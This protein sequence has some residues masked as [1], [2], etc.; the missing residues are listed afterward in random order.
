MNNLRQVTLWGQITL[1]AASTLT[2]MAGATI[3]PSLPA[4]QT[5]FESKENAGFL[6][7]LVLT[8]PALFIV[9]GAPLAGFLI[10]HF[11]RKT[12]LLI[13][14][15]LYAAAGSSGFFLDSLTLILVGRALLGLAVAGIMTSVT[16]LIAD[17]FTGDARS[18]LLG[19]QASFMALGGVLFLLFGGLL[20]DLSWRYPFLIYLFPLILL[21]LII[22]AL[23]EPPR[24]EKEL[25]DA[26]NL[27]GF[28]AAHPALPAIY[29]LGFTGMA[30][31]YLI[32]VQLPFHLQSISNATAA[33]SGLAIAASNF[34][35]ALVSLKYKSFRKRLSFV[36]LYAIAFALMATGFVVIGLA[37]NYWLVLIGL[38]ISGLGTGFLLPN[39]SSWLTSI[40]P[41]SL[42]GRAIGGLTMAIFLGQFVSPFYSQPL[43]A[44]F[45]VGNSFL[46]LAAILGFVAAL[47]LLFS[48]KNINY[49][50]EAVY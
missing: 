24:Q 15:A 13:S 36:Q 21:P 43:G 28:L 37:E 9:L 32:P 11:G 35:S 6:V 44:Q 14:A 30:S 1:L 8:L 45:G 26:P 5:A 34:F 33:Q 47:A 27:F 40:V 25:A 49:E 50:S 46:I 19:L 39:A 29:A 31:F 22:F 3:A 20:A 4:M 23:F 42:R 18:R 2:V 7:R 12:L 10:D 48:F 17:Y 38:A 41:E 16:T